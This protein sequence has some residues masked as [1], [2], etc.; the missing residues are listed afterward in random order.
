MINTLILLLVF[1]GMGL[2]WMAQFFKAS[3]WQKILGESFFIGVFK[4]MVIY[5]LFQWLGL[6]INNYFLFYLCFA[7]STVTIGYYVFV[8]KRIIINGVRERLSLKPH[9]SK[10]LVILAVFVFIHL[11]FIETQNQSLPLFA[12]DAWYGWVAKAKIWYFYGINES[13]VGRVEWFSAKGALTSPIHHY[14]D[15][16]S[17]LYVF[18]SGIFDWNETRL[19]AIYPAMFISF[20]LLIYGNVKLITQ[21]S[22]L[23]FGFVFVLVSLPYVNNHIILSGYADIWMAAYLFISFVNIQQY[24]LTHQKRFLI[25]SAISLI[26][27]LMFKLEAW[28]WVNIAIMSVG[29]SLL[30]KFSQRKAYFILACVIAIW[31]L[32]GGISIGE[33][34][35]TPEVVAVPWIGE[36]QLQFV[37]T[38]D[39]WLETFF[40]SNNWYFLW[41]FLLIVVI[42]SSKIKDRKLLALPGLFL[43]FST[44]FLFVLFYMTKASVFANDFTSSNRVIL[45]ILPIYIYFIAIIISEYSK[46]LNSKKKES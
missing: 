16:L 3:N 12:W 15:G 42:I 9:F 46:Q 1:T 8:Y 29:L 34:K 40:M 37:N 41:Y 31:Y 17:L 39:A 19:N 33:F 18:N 13:L 26:S 45:Q 23:A 25:L 10:I 14:P 2:P 35:I 21:S 38:T 44:I 20:I 6:D 4:I 24:F 22:Y 5:N 27:M 7:F 32:F 11:V 28:V 36:F 43:V 30:S